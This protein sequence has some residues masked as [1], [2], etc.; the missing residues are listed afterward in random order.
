MV[1]T[2]L[3]LIDTLLNRGRYLQQLGRHHDALRVL[4]RLAGF[5]DLPAGVAEEAQFRLG[6]LQLRRRRYARARRHLAAALRHRPDNARYHYLLAGALDSGRAGDPGRAAE[7]YRTSL[8][9][10]P[11][12]TDCLCA[13]GALALRLGQTEEGLRRLRAA[14]GLAPDD[15]KVLAKVVAGLR[16]ANRADEARGRL[17]A[18]RF[19]HPRDGRY[20][21]LWNQFQFQHARRAQDALGRAK[22]TAAQ[23]GPVLLPFVRPEGAGK[24]PARLRGHTA[25]HDGPA[26]PRRAG[27]PDQRHAQ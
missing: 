20:L 13:A 3:N 22:T 18:A 10:D 24:R 26:A 21:Q 14:A 2:T 6:E 23:G 5:R 7:H 9:L 16:L 27:R 4:S 11:T 12:Q 1:S 17:L 15:L 19:R 8:D 25:R